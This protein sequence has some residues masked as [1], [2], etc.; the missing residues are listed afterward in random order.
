M[1]TKITPENVIFNTDEIKNFSIPLCNNKKD[2]VCIYLSDD[3]LAHDE[4]L[5]D[6]YKVKIANF[7]N[8][9]EQWNDQCVAKIINES[10]KLY[11]RECLEHNISLVNIFILFEQNEDE[12]YGLEFGVDF[13]EHGFGIKISENIISE[14][15]TADVAFC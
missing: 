13:D 15:G 3:L 7:I 9:S 6:E 1:L 2:S 11:Q 10:P 12:L 5:K 14:I 4:K 8:R